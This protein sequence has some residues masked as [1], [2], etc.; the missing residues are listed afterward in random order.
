MFVQN[1][2]LAKYFKLIEFRQKE[3]AKSGIVEIHHI[4][5]KSMGGS[6]KKQNLVYLTAR[7]HYIAHKFLCRITSGK[8]LEKMIHALWGMSNRCINNPDHNYLTSKNYESARKLFLTIAGN[9]TRGKTYEEIYGKEKADQL[10]LSRAR[11]LS[12]NRKGKT[13]EEIFGT[14]KA[15]W[16]RS[17]VSAS[18]KKKKGTVWSDEAKLKLSLASSGKKYDKK[19][20]SICNRLI[21]VN[22]FKKHQQIHLPKEIPQK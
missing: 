17:K 7:E 15:I 3:P 8:N 12:E 19:L 11:S 2:Y 13:W 22:N 6:N 9:S 10:K 14:E 4:I 16:M 20:C 18:S 1:K 5:P 21:S